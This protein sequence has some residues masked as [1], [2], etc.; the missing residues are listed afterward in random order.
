MSDEKARQGMCC[1]RR[2][3]VA[4]VEAVPFA[5]LRAPS[6]RYAHYRK[7]GMIYQDLGLI[8]TLEVKGFG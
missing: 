6:Y 2:I 7:S 3:A 1:N 8:Y 5:P 4:S